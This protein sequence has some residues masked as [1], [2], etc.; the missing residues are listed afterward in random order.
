MKTEKGQTTITLLPTVA[1]EELAA[2]DILEAL[3][4]AGDDLDTLFVKNLKIDEQGV[5]A[6][7]THR[8]ASSIK[9][10]SLNL[11]RGDWNQALQ[12]LAGEA[13]K[14][15][16]LEELLISGGGEA[17]TGF[18][19]LLSSGR[20][21]KLRS[22]TTCMSAKGAA[23]FREVELSE[24]RLTSLAITTYF[25]L[26]EFR[27]EGARAL[28]E[29]PCLSKL[30]RLSI[31][32]KHS[33]Y[34][35]GARAIAESAIFSELQELE[36]KDDLIRDEGAEALASSPSLKRLRA[37]ALPANGIGEAGA[38]AIATSP[39]FVQLESL[40]LSGNP[41]NER[42]AQALASSAMLANLRRLYL[43]R[44][45]INAEGAGFLAKS[46]YF[47]N[48]V[49]LDLRGNTILE[50]EDIWYDQGS[51]IGSTPPDEEAKWLRERFGDG[52]RL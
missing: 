3:D 28:A 24:P 40:D 21:L 20:L 14:L 5:A 44:A 13:S 29:S 52:V 16:N 45:E 30:N 17:T 31:G 47:Q 6:I 41:V 9:S 7:A 32:A 18:T 8:K 4:V 11:L 39:N 38:I 27:A 22:L 43:S 35:E 33:I 10:L 42:G 50:E 2:S 51:P 34:A 48:L 23:A 36:I 37:V 46:P 15:S 19:A 26:A 49:L 1:G 25:G 12:I